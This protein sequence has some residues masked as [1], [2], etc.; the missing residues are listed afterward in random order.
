[1]LISDMGRGVARQSPIITNSRLRYQ[2]LSDTSPNA[3]VPFAAPADLSPEA[4]SFSHKKNLVI[5]VP[6]YKRE[7]L[8][9][10]LFG[11]L[12]ACAAELREIG[13]LLVCINDSPDYPL[14]DET[15]CRWFGNLEQEEIDTIYLC[16]SENGDLS[17]P[18]TSAY[19]LPINSTLIAF[20]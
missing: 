1:M 20:C 19:G 12:L 8:V 2:A 5:V 10:S 16:N 9:T 6:L 18:A 4:L 3:Y 15:I 13:A 14:L 11:S 17:I 7:D